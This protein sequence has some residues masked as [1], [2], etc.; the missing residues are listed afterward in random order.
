MKDGRSST[1]Q[2]HIRRA[3]EMLACVALLVTFGNAAADDV[4][5]RLGG[6]LIS[7]SPAVAARLAGLARQVVERCGPNSV[8]HPDN[9]G[10]FAQFAGDRWQRALGR[11]R[12]HVVF[13]D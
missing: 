7:L 2:A 9:F 4:S 8:R 10:P 1:F 11:S 3:F 6:K 12:L 5:L 13:K